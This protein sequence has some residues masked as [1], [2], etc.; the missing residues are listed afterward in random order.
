MYNDNHMMYIKTS[1][2]KFHSKTPNGRVLGNYYEFSSNTRLF[3]VIKVFQPQ[4]PIKV[5]ENREFKEFSQNGNITKFSNYDNI[6]VEKLVLT[7]R[8]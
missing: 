7:N 1:E 3:V 2:H 5:T 4:D 6:T 8:E